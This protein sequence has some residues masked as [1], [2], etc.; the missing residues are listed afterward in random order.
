MYRRTGVELM[1]LILASALA[2]VLPSPL[3]ASPAHSGDLLVIDADAGTGF[4]G[5]LFTVN[6]TTG[7]RTILSDFGDGTQ[8]P[9]GIR[10]L[11][12]VV[13]A[14][15]DLLVID[16]DAGTGSHGALF[17]VDPATGARTI[18]SDFGDGTQ[19]PTGVTPF[20]VALD[21]AGTILVIDADA[22]TGTNGALFTVDPIT[23]ARAILSD[24][25]DGTQ[26]PTGA[27]PLG[28]ALDA[29]GTILVMDATAGTGS[30][31]ALFTVDPI[32]GARTILSD[33]GNV[34]QGPTGVF[35]QLV[36]VDAA[37]TILVTDVLAGT[38]FHGAL[39]T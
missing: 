38:G 1:T 28:V 20:S 19:G 39:F 11:G 36:T 12:I 29:A 32:T 26:G 9:T 22:G 6:P 7:S 2:F 16:A 13:D 35:P 8:G 27:T 37:G 25:G 33:F 34:I 15:G 17:T 24:F 14:T 10:P 3:A 21:A 18:L 4:D 30:H 23:G 5:A 31:G